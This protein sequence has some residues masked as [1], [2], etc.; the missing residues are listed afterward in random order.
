MVPPGTYKIKIHSEGYY[1]A[2]FENI[3]I[4]Q[5]EKLQKNFELMPIKSN[6]QPISNAG[7]DQEVERLNKF[8]IVCTDHVGNQ[9]EKEIFINRNVQKVFDI[10]SRMSI[11]LFPFVLK[12]PYNI[13]NMIFSKLDN[14]KRFNI[15]RK[16][17][18]QSEVDMNFKPEIEINE[19]KNSLE[20]K[21]WATLP[22][23]NDDDYILKSDTL[24][25]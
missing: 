4:K 15:K 8:K 22:N 20:L 2:L 3:G 16:T 10:D 24:G 1:E 6:Q 18:S 7:P 23:Q 14:S 9:T 13:Y 25:K 11:I 17:D 19:N 5:E 21:L 12:E